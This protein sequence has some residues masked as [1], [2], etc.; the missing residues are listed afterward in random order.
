M[1]RKWAGGSGRPRNRSTVRAGARAQRHGRVHAMGWI[2]LRGLDSDLG[3][4]RQGRLLYIDP[5]RGVR[6]LSHATRNSARRTSPATSRTSAKKR[7]KISTNPG[8]YASGRRFKSDDVLVGKITPK[9]ETQ[10]SPE[11]RLL[12][13]DLRREGRRRARHIAA[14]CLLGVSGTV[15]GAQVFSRRGVEKDERAQVIEEQEIERLRKDQEDEV[16][17]IRDS[18]T[19]RKISD[20][21]INGKKC[22]QSSGRRPDRRRQLD[23]SE[24]RRLHRTPYSTKSRRGVGATSSSSGCSGAGEDRPGSIR[25]L[26]IKATVI[27]AVFDEKISRSEEGR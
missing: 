9:G 20:M 11:E 21:L 7:S 10:L 18:M 5:H 3:A 27:K 24:G 17:I 2:Q 19:L 15:I 8:S 16:R 22:G 1:C 4:R 26:M 12:A 23:R 25:E 13:R 6:V 14:V